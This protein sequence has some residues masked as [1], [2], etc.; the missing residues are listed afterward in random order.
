MGRELFAMYVKSGKRCKT[1]SEFK[2]YLL[3][4]Q[5][6][7]YV[8]LYRNKEEEFKAAMEKVEEA[9]EKAITEYKYLLLP[10][11]QIS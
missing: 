9:V 10:K 4:R 5:T 6:T 8:F 11:W 1:L 2:I 7:G 3:S